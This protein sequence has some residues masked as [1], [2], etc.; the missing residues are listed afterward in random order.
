MNDK[1]EE[2]IA[3]IAGTIAVILMAV[4]AILLFL[5]ASVWIYDTFL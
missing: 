4:I 3:E 5:S 2:R 1:D